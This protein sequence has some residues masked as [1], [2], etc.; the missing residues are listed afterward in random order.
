MDHT[1]I[2]RGMRAFQPLSTI[3]HL[4]ITKKRLKGAPLI[5]PLSRAEPDQDHGEGKVFEDEA[6]LQHWDDWPR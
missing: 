3:G 5:T 1:E 6:T 4:K 2:G